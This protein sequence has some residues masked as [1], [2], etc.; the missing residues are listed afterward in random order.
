[1]ILFVF[2]EIIKIQ[3]DDF[4]KD[5]QEDEMDLSDGEGDATPAKKRKADSGTGEF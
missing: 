5:R 3:Q 1:M 4:L 2:Q